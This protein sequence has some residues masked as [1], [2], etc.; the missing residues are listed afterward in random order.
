MSTIYEEDAVDEA[1]VKLVSVLMA[2]MGKTDE[3]TR[4]LLENALSDYTRAV[5]VMAQVEMVRAEDPEEW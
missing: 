5:V 3:T 4:V 2:G 1:E